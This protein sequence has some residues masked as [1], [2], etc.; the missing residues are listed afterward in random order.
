M[1][2]RTIFHGFDDSVKSYANEDR[3]TREAIKTADAF[4][5]MCNV[6]IVPIKL[7]ASDK[8]RYTAIF[9]NFTYEQDAINTARLGWTTYA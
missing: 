4:N 9:S 5:G 8:I 7:F 1:T 6:R 2:L 3:C